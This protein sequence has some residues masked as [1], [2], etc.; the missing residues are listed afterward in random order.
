M[1]LVRMRTATFSV[2]HGGRLAAGQLVDV[3]DDVSRRWLKNGLAGGENDAAAKAALGHS[4]G[5]LLAEVERLQAEL[6]RLQAGAAAGPSLP[7]DG[8]PYAG[9]GDELASLD[10][11]SEQQRVNLGRAGFGTLAQIRA[12]TEDELSE[13][14]KIGA[15]TVVKLRHAAEPGNTPSP[16]RNP[17]PI[18]PPR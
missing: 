7:D 5:A 12:A 14:D 13:V 3:E 11:L 9:A 10:F 18:N 16:T 17:A 4:T 2:D 8:D 6:A 1:P 15:S